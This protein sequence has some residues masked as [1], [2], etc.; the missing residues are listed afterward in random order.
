MGR[1][2]GPIRER[3]TLADYANRFPEMFNVTT[4]ATGNT[5]T[6]T[7]DEHTIEEKYVILFSETDKMVVPQDSTVNLFGCLEIPDTTTS[8]TFDDLIIR[9]TVEGSL[10]QHSSSTIEMG[11][12]SG[13]Y[14][15]G[16]RVS[17][18][19]VMTQNAGGVITL[20]NIASSSFA[21]G[22]SARGIEITGLFSSGT[23]LTTSGKITIGDVSGTG[24][25]IVVINSGTMTQ[26][27]GGEIEI[28]D[29]LGTQI[30]EGIVISSSG[31]LET[32]G[33]ITIGDVSDTGRGIDISSASATMTQNADGE[34]VI[35]DISGTSA[36][37]FHT[38]DTL[39]TSGKITIRDILNGGDGI[40]IVR[41][42]TFTQNEGGEI[43]IARVSDTGSAGIDTF[44][45]LNI[46]G[47]ITIGD[48][49][50][51]GNGIDLDSTQGR[52]TLTAGGEITIDNVSGTDSSGIILEQATTG[53]IIIQNGGKI[54][55]VN[56]LEDA[57]GI[58]NNARITQNGGEITINNVSGEDT[59]GILSTF[60][61]L[62]V[63]ASIKVF[64]VQSG[65]AGI[66]STVP[67][68]ID[69]QGTVT[70]SNTGTGI[71]YSDAIGG[72]SVNPPTANF[73]GGGD[74]D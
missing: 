72:A 26:N 12:F 17:N 48:V 51:G 32:T 4:D 20:G 15:R 55:I 61:S 44:S 60:A 10:I 42:A 13:D 65:A 50:N 24:V 71:K 27:A 63:K 25:G 68:G 69:N 2:P 14:L 29:I 1:G 3:I 8:G 41:G 19:G 45:A 9:I 53:A 57:I 16:I 31:T 43:A 23:Q 18:N 7:A 66:A 21:A 49:L 36:R 59:I 30:P 47:K 40:V 62:T 70:V 33:K 64:N 6:F 5:Y 54:T 38:I 46:A 56:V 73:V 28:G 67:D 39:T 11:S 34:I 58:L 37:G 35:R 74:Y 22:G 52:L